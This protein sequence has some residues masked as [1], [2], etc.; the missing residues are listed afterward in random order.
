[1]R[2]LTTLRP[3]RQRKKLNITFLL[4]LYSF[5]ANGFL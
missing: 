1:V 5:V 3:L 2:N 4:S